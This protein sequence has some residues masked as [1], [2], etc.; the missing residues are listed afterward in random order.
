[1]LVPVLKTPAASTHAP[2]SSHAG[3]WWSAPT[4]GAGHYWTFPELARTKMTIEA[5]HDTSLVLLRYIK[6]DGFCLRITLPQYAHS[7]VR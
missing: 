7:P 5:A 6:V 2:T 4:C 3:E 1:V